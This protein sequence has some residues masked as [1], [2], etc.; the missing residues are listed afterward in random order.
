MKEMGFEY[1]S[2]NASPKNYNRMY[3]ATEISIDVKNV[4]SVC[5][6]ISYEVSF[7]MAE[8]EWNFKFDKIGFEQTIRTKY[9]A[10][11][12]FIRASYY[13]QGFL[14]IK[15]SIKILDKRS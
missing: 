11:C 6:S 1:L 5:Y 9:H 15:Y 14:V 7:F 2:T 4:T 10:S 8:E 3:K 12:K 13:T